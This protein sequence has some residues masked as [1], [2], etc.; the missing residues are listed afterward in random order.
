MRDRE[1]F[2]WFHVKR[3]GSGSVS[4]TVDLLELTRGG[5]GWRSREEQASVDYA[6]LAAARRAVSEMRGSEAALLEFVRGHWH[7]RDLSSPNGRKMS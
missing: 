2:A 4:L 5:R 7:Y 6:S 3:S 1:L